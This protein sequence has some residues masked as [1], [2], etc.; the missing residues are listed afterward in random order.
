MHS[1]ALKDAEARI[2]AL[3]REVGSVREDLRRET[4]RRE[5]ALVQA[6]EAQEAKEATDGK[7]Q[8]LGYANRKLAA[9]LEA[10]QSTA[11]ATSERDKRGVRGVRAGSAG[12]AAGGSGQP[13]A[14]CAEGAAAAAT[15]AGRARA[16][17]GQPGG[18]VAG[19]CCTQP[20]PDDRAAVRHLP[21]PA[22]P[23][24]SPSRP[25]CCYQGWAGRW[26][27]GGRQWWWRGAGAAWGS[28]WWWW[29]SSG[30]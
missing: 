17:P 10:V 23:A 5:R 4:K 16:Q 29:A 18:S 1:D 14:Q 25:H 21:R 2:R 30:A 24:P 9:Q 27:C 8:E 7:L 6:K 15:R 19:Q 11:K 20:D 3:V 22:G 28:A 26:Q 12:A 13:A